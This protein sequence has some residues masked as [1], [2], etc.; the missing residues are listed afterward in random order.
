MGTM[1]L[2]LG[3]RLTK[4]GVYALNA[5]AAPPQPRHARQALQWAARAVVLA[6][7][8]SMLLLILVSNLAGRLA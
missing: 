7:I 3:V 1:A 4:P 5:Q 8:A 6:A 2:L